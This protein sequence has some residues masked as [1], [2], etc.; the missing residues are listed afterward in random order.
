MKPLKQMKMM[1]KVKDE[2]GKKVK[3]TVFF[4]LFKKDRHTMYGV[5]VL[6]SHNLLGEE[7]E[8]KYST[9]LQPSEFGTS[10]FVTEPL[11]LECPYRNAAMRWAL[12]NARN[13]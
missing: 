7:T 4:K 11:E 8:W 13:I 1:R 9:E 10:V 3:V 5:V 12:E 2:N 6:K